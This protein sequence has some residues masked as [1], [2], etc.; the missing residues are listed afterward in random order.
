M[1]TWRIALILTIVCAYAAYVGLFYI[2]QRN[3][4]FPGQHWPALPA[5]APTQEGIDA[6]WLETSQGKVEAW[7][8]SPI[9]EPQEQKIP[10]MIMTHG[11]GEMIDMWV[12]PAREVRRQGF[13]V[14]LI[15]YPGY[16]R[17]AGKP[18]QAGITEAMLLGYDWLVAQ[19]QID[20]DKIVIFGRSIGGG[21]ACAL[22]AQRPSAALILFSTFQSVTSMAKARWLPSVLVKDP[23]DNLSVVENYSRPILLLHGDHD[24]VIPYAHSEVLHAAAPDSELI[25]YDCGHNDCVQDWIKFWQ[26]VMSFLRQAGVIDL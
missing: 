17:S 23:F 1:L 18:S 6:I 7:Y 9:G 19:P 3:L 13:G 10:T 8:L 16:G 11:N 14:L 12:E 15:E 26:D 4:I 24:E 2:V 22:A 5:Y 20:P 25:T 21:A